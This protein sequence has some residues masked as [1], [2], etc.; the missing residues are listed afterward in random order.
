MRSQALLALLLCSAPLQAAYTSPYV[1]PWTGRDKELLLL[2]RFKVASE[3]AEANLATAL[4]FTL[5]PA[6]EFGAELAVMT[7]QN[8]SFALEK[9]SVFGKRVLLSEFENAPFSLAAAGKV[10]VASASALVDATKHYHSHLDLDVC[11]SAGSEVMQPMQRGWA[12]RW[13]FNLGFVQ[14]IKGYPAPY[15][16]GQHDF[17]ANE[18]LYWTFGARVQKGFGNQVFTKGVGRVSYVATEFFSALTTRNLWA[19]P[20]TFSLRVKPRNTLVDAH[21]VILEVL[22]RHPIQFAV[23]SPY[24]W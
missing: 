8:C 21:Q 1:T 3:T 2:T 14:G 5:D 23:T 17:R 15:L 19:E 12:Q 16:E 11:L 20:F 9:F 18:N 7:A 24:H 10:Q 13:F 6:V 22:Y 4:D